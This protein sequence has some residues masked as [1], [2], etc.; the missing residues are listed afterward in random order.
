MDLIITKGEFGVRPQVTMTS[1]DFYELM[2]EEGIRNLIS[3]HYNL[4][5]KSNIKHLFPVEPEKLEAAKKRS[6]DF[7]VQICG[8]PQLYTNQ[9]GPPR[10]RARHLPFEIGEK[11]KD[12]WDFVN[13]SI[14]DNNQKYI[15]QTSDKKTYYIGIFYL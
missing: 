2:G 13:I 8:G 1:P 7:F 15:F 9:F 11:E 10:L 4:L 12:L 3:D 6:S 5:V 14:I